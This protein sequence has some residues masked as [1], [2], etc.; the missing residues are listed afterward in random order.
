MRPVNLIPPEERRGSSAP[1]RTG[2]LAYIAIG[3]LVAVLVGVTAVVTTD[4][5]ISDRRSELAVVEQRQAAADSQL[6]GL[7]SFASLRSVADQRTA[8]V[9]SLAKSRF[10]WVRVMRELSRILPSDVWLVNVTGSVRPD[11][12]VDSGAAIAPRGNIS[13]PA[14]EIIGCATGQDAV[15]RFI[16][17]L[18]D[19]DGVTRVGVDSSKRPES[20][21]AG[22]AGAGSGK[23]DDCRTKDTVTRFELVVAFDGV[24]A[25]AVPGATPAAPA[26]GS[27]TAAASSDSSGVAETQTQQA[28]AKQSAATQTA[29]AQKATNLVP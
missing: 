19:I 6:K 21:T 23:S 22:A 12:Q 2:P 29:K 17:D 26:A 14:I 7:Q 16:S 8:T 24:P 3:G 10:D 18:Q 27:A 11:V 20:T 25:P 13:G 15:A 5:K 9:A 28:A 4:K 1:A